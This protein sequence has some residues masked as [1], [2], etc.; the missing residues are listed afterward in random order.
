MEDI[1]LLKSMFKDDILVYKKKYCDDIYGTLPAE[2]LKA[3]GVTVSLFLNNKYGDQIAN[4][5]Y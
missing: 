2:S 1:D 5:E 3:M 4:M